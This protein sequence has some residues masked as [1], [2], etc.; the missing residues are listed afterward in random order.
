MRILRPLLTV[1]AIYFYLCRSILKQDLID[2][3]NHP[4]SRQKQVE[5][6]RGFIETGRCYTAGYKY[7][8]P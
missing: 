4:H 7:K 6:A 8:I 2:L 3:T 1:Y 5:T